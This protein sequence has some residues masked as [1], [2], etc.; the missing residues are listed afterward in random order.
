MFN[1]FRSRE[2]TVRI[3][4]GVLLGLVSLSMLV[5]LIPGGTG[6]GNASGQNVVAAVGD[7]KITAQDVQ[8]AIQRLTRNQTNLPKGV[9]AMYLP[10][11][12][13]QLA[14]SVPHFSL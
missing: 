13:N 11:I 4:L 2:R 6:T 9:L 8:R 3:M 5:Y 7:D 10:S 14:I 12:V 1:L